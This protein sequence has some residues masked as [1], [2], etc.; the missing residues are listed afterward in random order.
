MPVKLQALQIPFK[1]KTNI[2][3]FDLTTKKISGTQLVFKMEK[4][5]IKF[6]ET[7]PNRFRLV[8]HY[9]IIRKDVERI[10]IILRG[11]VN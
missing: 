4:M 10:L 1:I 2:I 8:T 11:M 6:F 9:G 7:S 5:G 3:Y